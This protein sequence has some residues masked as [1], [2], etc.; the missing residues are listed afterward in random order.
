[1]VAYHLSKLTYH[2]YKIYITFLL[3]I[4]NY[5]KEHV[6]KC[7]TAHDVYG[8]IQAVVRCFLLVLMVALDVYDMTSH[9]RV[10][11]VCFQLKKNMRDCPHVSNRY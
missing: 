3:T 5:N 8:Q 1:M 2:P 4:A 7:T 6:I 11:L 9:S 10:L